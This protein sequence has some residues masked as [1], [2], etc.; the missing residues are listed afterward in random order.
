MKITYLALA[1]IVL[2]LLIYYL[3]FR[4]TGRIETVQRSQDSAPGGAHAD[5]SKAWDVYAKLRSMALEVTPGQIKI[6]E[7]GN[8]SSVYGMVMDWSMGQGTV[9]FV[10][11]ATGDASL[12]TSTGGGMI[13]GGTHEKVSVATRSLVAHASA[14]LDQAKRTDETPLPGKDG[15]CLYFLTRNGRYL[16]RESMKRFEDRSSS[17]ITLFDEANEVITEL[18]LVQQK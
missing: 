8:D 11:M 6:P 16:A 9:T 3:T 2:I 15:A 18:R 10:F 12:Y 4:K 13:G 7:L 1:A 14:F 17:L 5:T